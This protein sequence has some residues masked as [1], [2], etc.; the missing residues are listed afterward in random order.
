MWVEIGGCSGGSRA[1]AVIPVA[2]PSTVA[3]AA[4]SRTE[5]STQHPSPFL[6]TTPFVRMAREWK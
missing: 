2:I 5:A 1:A 3:A 4:N 6:I